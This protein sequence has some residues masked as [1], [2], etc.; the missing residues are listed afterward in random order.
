MNKFFTTMLTLAALSLAIPAMAEDCWTTADPEVSAGGFYV[1][2]DLCQFEEV[3][4]CL[5]YICVYHERND[6]E[7]LQR[8]DEVV[9]NTCGQIDSDT[10]IV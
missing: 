8:G 7:G 6:I 5:V 9:D 1:D 4:P 10:I 3:D 2:N